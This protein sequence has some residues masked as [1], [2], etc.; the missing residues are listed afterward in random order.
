MSYVQPLANGIRTDHPVPGLPFVEDEHIPIDDPDAVEAIGRQDGAGTWGRCDIAHDSGEWVAF[1]TDPKN[2][3]LGWVI[4]FHPEHGRSVLL[5]RDRDATTAYSE[6]FRDK[7][8]LSRIGGYWWNGTTWYRPLQIFDWAGERYVPR[9]VRLPTVIT[10]ADLLDGTGRAELGRPA[11]IMQLGGEQSAVELAGYQ[12]HSGA[13]GQ[14][15]R[16]EQWRHDVALWAS[17]RTDDALP[18]AQCVV[19]VNAPE[20]FDAALLGVEEFATKAEIAAST[21]RAYIARDEAD[22]PALQATDGPRKRWAKPVVDDWIEQRRRDPGSVAT[23]LNASG[24]DGEDGEDTL[25]P[26]LRVLW[27]RLTEVIASEL[28][29]DAP[30]RRRWSRPHRNEHAVRNLSNQLGWIAA[31][32]LDSTVPFDALTS[33]LE[34]AVMW[35]LK[36][37]YTESMPEVGF[38]PQTGRMLGWFIEHR[39]SRVTNLFGAVIGEAERQLAIPREVTIRSLRDSIR[40]DGGFH[41]KTDQLDEF[42]DLVSPPRR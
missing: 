1:T 6:W 38:T 36:T 5:Y 9:E 7:P 39:P 18:L 25:A 15:A 10:A 42:L 20:L 31:L 22:I 19:T 34:D 32:H 28:W 37:Y 41:G 27:Q 24:G 2:P 35:Q 17:R 11:R 12:L 33:V 26:G 3:S 30:A 40:M 29:R 13:Q 14:L 23:L 8:L 4:R 16:A 21:L